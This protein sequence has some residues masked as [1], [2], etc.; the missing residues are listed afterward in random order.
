VGVVVAESPWRQTVRR[1]VPQRARRLARAIYRLL[2]LYWPRRILSQ[3]NNLPRQLED[4]SAQIE[5]QAKLGSLVLQ[6]LH[7]LEQEIEEFGK[8]ALSERKPLPEAESK[9][10]LREP[11]LTSSV[12]AA[13]DGSVLKVAIV[14]RSWGRRCGVAEYSAFLSERLGAPVV[15]SPADLPLD[16]DVALLQYEPGYYSGLD[17]LI[18]ELRL[19]RPSVIPVVD[20]HYILPEAAAELP[21]HAIVGVKRGF[22]PGTVRLSHIQ[23]LPVIHQERD[24]EELRLGSFGFAFPAKRYELIIDLAKRLRIGATILASHNNS[25]DGQGEISSA[26]LEKLKKLATD[27]IEIIDEF[28]PTEEIVRRLARCSHLISCMEDNGAQ[29]GSLRIMAA[30]GRPVISL[31]TTQAEDVGAILVDSLDEITIDF[32]RRCR[33][34]P[35][36]YDGMHDYN[37]LLDRLAQFKKDSH[38]LPGDD[39]EKVA[40][41]RKC[42]TGST[43]VLGIGTGFAANSIR[44]A[45]AADP[46]PERL[47]IAFTRYPHLDLRALDPRIQALSGF[48]TVVFDGI[49]QRMPLADA[50]NMVAMW[51]EAGAQRILLTAIQERATVNGSSGSERAWEPGQEQLLGLMP[52]GYTGNVSVAT[53]SRHAFL[54]MIKSKHRIAARA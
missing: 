46:D 25:T 51:A 39:D 22:Y 12:G 9:I 6:R 5:G 34:A 16:A 44:A 32:L 31:K 48:E 17:D 1:R 35:E 53:G 4:Q 7:R 45:V 13:P 10:R 14:C 26:Y 15:S 41:L 50:R 27:D 37:R 3:M 24:P 47:S 23:Q 8:Q 43:I 2:T 20:A 29:S 21:W 52:S 28:L 11:S 36:P 18:R 42:A 49:A 30:A 33:H 19:I 54:E 38:G 40:W